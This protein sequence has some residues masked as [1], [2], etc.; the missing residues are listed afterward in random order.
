M[1]FISGTMVAKYMYKR[2]LCPKHLINREELG[3]TG[4]WRGSEVLSVQKGKVR[5]ADSRMSPVPCQQLVLLKN[6]AVSTYKTR[7]RRWQSSGL[8]LTSMSPQ[9]P[10]EVGLCADCSHQSGEVLSPTRSLLDS[11]AP[12]A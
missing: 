2:L 3:L 12:Q 11:Q 1:H 9:G 4:P 6:A 7:Y 10:R 5:G 8:C